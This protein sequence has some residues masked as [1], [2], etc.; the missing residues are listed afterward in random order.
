M[1]KDKRKKRVGI[2][3]KDIFVKALKAALEAAVPLVPIL[4]SLFIHA[5]AKTGMTIGGLIGSL[6]HVAMSPEKWPDSVSNYVLDQDDADPMKWRVK[7]MDDVEFK[8]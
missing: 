1:P 2:T 4:Q 8:T 6:V 5:L 3:P 7:H